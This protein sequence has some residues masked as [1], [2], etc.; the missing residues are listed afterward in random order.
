TQIIASLERIARGIAIAGGVPEDRMPT[1][2][3]SESEYTTA[4][5]NDPALT[6]RVIPAIQRALGKEKV[7][8]HPPAMASEDF[9]YLGLENHQLRSF[10]FPLGPIDSDRIAASRNGGSP[11]PSLHSG[12]YYP[13]PEPTLR[14]GVMAMSAAVLELLKK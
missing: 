8:E 12:L 7:V 6:A 4:M 3:A 11:L 14:T 13:A 5:Y 9:G 10:M 1:V 2:K